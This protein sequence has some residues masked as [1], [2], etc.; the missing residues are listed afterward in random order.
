MRLKEKGVS[1]A[2]IHVDNNLQL[3]FFSSVETLEKEQ[4]AHEVSMCNLINSMS[5]GSTAPITVM[6]HAPSQF[7]GG[8][9]LWRGVDPSTMPLGEGGGHLPYME[10]FYCTFAH[11]C[12]TDLMKETAPVEGNCPVQIPNYAPFSTNLGGWG[13]TVIYS[14]MMSSKGIVYY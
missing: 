14:C 2:C 5:Y 7:G 9:G 4:L 11:M 12:S 1:F 3:T 6:P 8:W 10:D 13:I